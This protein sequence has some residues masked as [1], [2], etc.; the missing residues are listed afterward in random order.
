MAAI[1]TGVVDVSSVEKE[2]NDKYANN[3]NIRINDIVILGYVTDYSYYPIEFNI[4][5]GKITL[6]NNSNL[7]NR[8]LFVCSNRQYLNE[9]YTSSNNDYTASSNIIELRSSMKTA[10]NK[11]KFLI[12]LNGFYIGRN[13]YHVIIPSFDN[14][15]LKKN[16]IFDFPLPDKSQVDIIYM[17]SDEDMDNVKFNRDLKLYHREIFLK[18]S[19]YDIANYYLESYPIKVPYP[20]DLYPKG[21]HTFYVFSSEHEHLIQ[22]V[23]YDFFN[24]YD[25]I[26]LRFDRRHLNIPANY[27]ERYI[28]F[29]FPFVRR[30]WEETDY[31]YENTEDS[32]GTRSGI[33]YFISESISTDANGNIK[34]SPKFT[35]YTLTK[36][37]FL[38]FSNTTFIDPERYNIIANDHLQ[39]ISAYD[40]ADC[41]NSAYN[42]VIFAEN[43]AVA[44][45]YTQFT[46]DIYDITATVDGQTVFNLPRKSLVQD[47][48]IFR[49]SVIM[50]QGDRYIWDKD[51]QKITLTNPYDGFVKGHTMQVVY[52]R[53]KDTVYDRDTIVIRKFY[54]NINTN[55]YVDLPQAIFN[56]LAFDYSNLMLFV[57]TAYLEPSRYTISSTGRLTFTNPKDIGVLVPGKHLTGILLERVKISGS[58]SDDGMNHSKNKFLSVVDDDTFIWFD[59]QITKVHT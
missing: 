48:M 1:G 34:F 2:L 22:N 23:D 37:N 39:M 32:F 3:P 5:D 56:N 6:N 36:N 57:N 35:Q 46:F 27:L 24:G 8:R 21:P 43:K 26:A 50:D 51:G 16:I 13:H 44:N 40:K 9:T 19:Q 10:W 7:L 17:E 38:L 33:T 59:E 29:V 4:V 18:D 11:D 14:E 52:Y 25:Y 45:K 31:N 20:Y 49:G 12:F 42:M 54:I 41:V 15:Y 30:D 58:V 55:E 47:F 28:S 53:N